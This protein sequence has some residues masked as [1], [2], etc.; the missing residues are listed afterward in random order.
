MRGMGYC[1]RLIYLNRE[2]MKLFIFS[3]INIS[4]KKIFTYHI[5]LF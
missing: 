1:R 2:I 5:P 3:A 4:T